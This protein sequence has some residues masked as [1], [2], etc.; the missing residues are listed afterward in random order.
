MELGNCKS[1]QSRGEGNQL[2]EERQL[3]VGGESEVG[4]LVL[5]FA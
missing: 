4:D 2:G 5:P 3:R 1:V